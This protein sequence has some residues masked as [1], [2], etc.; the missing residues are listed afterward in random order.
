MLMAPPEHGLG[1]LDEVR[2]P[3]VA[4]EQQAPVRQV[5]VVV[6]NYNGIADTL[7]CLESLRAQTCTGL[8]TLVI[9]NGSRDD[10]LGRIATGFPEVEILALG[11]NRGWAGGNNVGLRL[12]LERGFAAICLLN[13]DT[14][15]RPDALAELMAAAEAVGEPC[16][17]HPVIHDFDDTSRPQ[18]APGPAPATPDAT[19]RLL[20]ERHE[21][22]EISWAYG[23]CLLI[24][25][26]L[27][28]RIGLLDERFFLQLEEQDYFRRAQA[29]GLRSYCA[30]RARILHKESASF[31]GRITANKTY[32]Q[33]RN[34]LLLAEKHDAS[35][36][37]VLRAL[38]HLL[39]SLRHQAR[40]VSP[41]AASRLGFVR[42]AASGEPV[43]RA[44][45]QGIFDYLRRRFGPRPAAH[46]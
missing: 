37:G 34:A 4:T 35:A 38:R 22:V 15:L 12:G 32:Y 46:R 30:L 8:A 45:R 31:G 39:W 24:P 9:D 33:V 41:R 26:T 18:L 42:W 44:V 25:A 14:V 21:V 36:A 2:G 28:H 1:S 27:A 3:A 16:L 43:A 20:A 7:A 19:A 29:V 23:A 13:N 40:A 6:L 5:L 11:E 17:M 10:D